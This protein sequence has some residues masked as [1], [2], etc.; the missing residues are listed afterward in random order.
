MRTSTALCIGLGICISSCTYECRDCIDFAERLPLYVDSVEA[1]CRDASIETNE[2]CR[3][4][5]TTE[6]KHL[7]EE[8]LHRLDDVSNVKRCEIA[9][10]KN[11]MAHEEEEV[12]VV[13]LADRADIVQVIVSFTELG[14]QYVLRGITPTG[15]M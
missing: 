12:F 8:L 10:V 7:Y 13:Y 9:Y 5:L 15:M 2:F 6:R 14:D 4:S 11:D 1:I 3:N